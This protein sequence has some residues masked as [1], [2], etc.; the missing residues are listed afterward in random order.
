MVPNQEL[1]I[2]LDGICG[3]EADEKC[4]CLCFSNAASTS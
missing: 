2:Y 1:R 4:Y 3:S